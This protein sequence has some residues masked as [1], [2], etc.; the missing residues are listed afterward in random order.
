MP[1]KN[2]IIAGVEKVRS[3]DSAPILTV[4]F[5][6]MLLMGTGFAK[7]DTL[8]T[9]DDTYIDLLRPSENFGGHARLIVRDLSLG[10]VGGETRT[11]LRFDLSTL[12]DQV[13]QAILRLRVARIVEAG[14]IDLYRV[15]DAWDE[16]TLTAAT[17]AH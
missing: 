11:F 7:A 6:T 4:L 14:S 12:P 3:T 5:L 13:D 1:S 16:E 17:A 9:T 2:Q 10:G 15:D 8:H